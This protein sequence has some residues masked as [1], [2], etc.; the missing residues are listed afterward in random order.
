[1]SYIFNVSKQFNFEVNFQN[2]SK[3]ITLS[4]VRV[5]IVTCVHQSLLNWVTKFMIQ[6]N[7]IFKYAGNIDLTVQA[8]L[9]I[10][11]LDNANISMQK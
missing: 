4:F 2:Y 10:G 1:M 6:W 9:T 8:I 3:I 5:S 7:D 11:L